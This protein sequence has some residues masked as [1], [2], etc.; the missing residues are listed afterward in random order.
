MGEKEIEYT[1][2][3]FTKVA[4][5]LKHET[6]GIGKPEDY[7]LEAKKIKN[8]YKKDSEKTESKKITFPVPVPAPQ[9][10]R[11]ASLPK[12]P[13]RSRFN[14]VIKK[15]FSNKKRTLEQKP[16]IKGDNKLKVD[17][18]PLFKTAH[19]DKSFSE[20]KK[21]EDNTKLLKQI[22]S[23]RYALEKPKP[24]I[25]IT[26]EEA[27]EIEDR[28][29]K[30]FKQHNLPEPEKSKPIFKMDFNVLKNKNLEEEQKSKQ[31]QEQEQK[32]PLSQTRNTIKTP[33]KIAEIIEEKSRIQ[34][35]DII[36][37]PIKVNQAGFKTQFDNL[38][39]AALKKKISEDKKS[40][41]EVLLE[42]FK[43]SKNKLKPEFEEELSL[44][45]LM[46]DK[47]NPKIFK[48]IL[49]T[50]R[51]ND[52]TKKIISKEI[53]HFEKSKGKQKNKK[54]SL[55]HFELPEFKIPSLFRPDFSKDNSPSVEEKIPVL[56]KNKNLPIL[57]EQTRES[58][59]KS[60]HH[61]NVSNRNNPAMLNP[62]SN[63]P[64]IVT[65]PKK[66]EV[67]RIPNKIILEYSEVQAIKSK[68]SELSF[69]LKRV[70]K[71]LNDSLILEKKQSQNQIEKISNANDILKSD[72]LRIKEN[73]EIK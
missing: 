24:E 16:I 52:A 69:T 57:I 53:K 18:R 21:G 41:E 10:E 39:I 28:T 70:S 19:P 15:L 33:K 47:F 14:G 9:K 17:K 11:F 37:E 48:N 54:T 8:P 36:I 59:E 62:L 29:S 42:N 3:L 58:Q 45:D 44:P 50:P 1:S 38:E 51:A 65:S 71:Q 4:E 49:E 46:P 30:I 22:L 2:D 43:T 31:E 40:K 12:V 25:T 64:A 35:P 67:K 32:Q 56:G 34:L 27:L 73:F 23:P 26:L 5:Q 68:F 6:S 55:M 13:R 20:Q 72:I 60:H 7:V 66:R 63:Q 61:I